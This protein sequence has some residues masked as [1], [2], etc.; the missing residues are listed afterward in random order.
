MYIYERMCNIKRIKV[1]VL[2]YD[3]NRDNQYIQSE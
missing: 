3:L 1:T 2:I